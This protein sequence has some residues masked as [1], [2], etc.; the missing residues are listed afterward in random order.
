M[1]RVAVVGQL[2]LRQPGPKPSLA[3]PFAIWRARGE[4]STRG[5]VRLILAMPAVYYARDGGW[6]GSDAFLHQVHKYLTVFSAVS[7]IQMPKAAPAWAPGG[8]PA[9]E[10]S[11][12]RSP[13]QL[14]R[15]PRFLDPWSG[16]GLI[17]LAT[18]LAGGTGPHIPTD[19]DRQAQMNWPAR[20]ASS[21][22]VTARPGPGAGR[23]SAKSGRACAGP[24]PQRAPSFSHSHRHRDP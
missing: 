21:S 23:L 13:Y 16:P 12:V 7:T 4:S 3:K 11:D 10:S 19:R 1:L 15:N 9:K 22:K 14:P 18:A 8:R 2:L 17:P 6:P 5:R 24:G 20:S